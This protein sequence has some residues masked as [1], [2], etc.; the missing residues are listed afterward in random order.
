MLLI[1]I[2]G[3]IASGKTEVAKVFRKKGATI[4]SGDEIGR[5]VVEGNKSVLKKLVKVFGE[6]IMRDDGTLNRHRLG[7]IS[8]SSVRGKDK[9]NR[10]V[11]P[12]LLRELRSRVRNLKG[13]RKSSMPL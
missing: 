10:I 1:G 11:H 9:L 2:T 12:P 8:F 7:E 3:G 4:L 6:H 5:K 13:K